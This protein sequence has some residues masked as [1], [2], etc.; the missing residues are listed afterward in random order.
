MKW[1][2]EVG[3]HILYFALKFYLICIAMDMQ[4]SWEGDIKKK[5]ILQSSWKRFAFCIYIGWML[6]MYK[7]KILYV[8]LYAFVFLKCVVI[9]LHYLEVFLDIIA[10]SA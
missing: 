3:K 7:C 6:N 10:A 2:P 8:L 1:A 4:I 9:F 5:K